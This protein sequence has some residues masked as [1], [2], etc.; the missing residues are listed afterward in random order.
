MANED[1]KQEKAKKKRIH[2]EE[3]REREFCLKKIQIC[4]YITYHL[5]INILSK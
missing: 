3:E 4:S 2:K 5:Y 1:R